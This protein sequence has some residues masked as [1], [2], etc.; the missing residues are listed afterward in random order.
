MLLL[1]NYIWDYAWE[2][3]EHACMLWFNINSIVKNQ[4]YIKHVYW[5]IYVP[6]TEIV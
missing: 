1:V 5:F 4:K 6:I 3:Y 2:K